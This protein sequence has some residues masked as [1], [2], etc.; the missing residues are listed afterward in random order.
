MTG[1]PS[2]RFYATAPHP[3]SY[4]EGQEATTLFV[5][6]DTELSDPELVKLTE[7][8]FRRSG[9]Y[10][11]RPYCDHCHACISV[12]IPVADFKPKRRHQRTLRRNSEV[13]YDLSSP[14]LDDPHYRLYAN[15][16]EARHAD[17]DMYP[18][19]PSQYEAFLAAGDTR[20]HFLNAR[21]D[22]QLVATML[23]DQ[24][25]G[26]GLSAVYTFFDPDPLFEPRSFGRLLILELIRRARESNLPYVYLGYWIRDCKKM[27][28]KTE[29]RPIE[30]LIN[31]RW[32]RAD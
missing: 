26:H 11:Y 25:P 19:S 31:G 24:I 10:V 30:M 13:I 22:G 8:G 17:G 9:R 3:C 18:P 29:Y 1:F 6:P 23:F 12:R 4:L 5:A 7:S 20:S 16:I 21:I 27:A 15:Y 2:L 14:R 32:I 28:Y